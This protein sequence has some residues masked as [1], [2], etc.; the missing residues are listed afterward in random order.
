MQGVRA[1]HEAVTG[2]VLHPADGGTRPT[3]ERS[4]VACMT[5]PSLS[6]AEQTEVDRFGI[7]DDDVI[8]RLEEHFDD[9]LPCTLD[10]AEATHEISSRCCGE[11]AFLCAQHAVWHRGRWTGEIARRGVICAHCMH[12]WP[13]SDYDDVVRM[14]AL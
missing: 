12:D 10:G 8:S 9:V 6:P 11:T 2:G 4:A 5:A 1:A 3:Q 7:H 14:V 13:P